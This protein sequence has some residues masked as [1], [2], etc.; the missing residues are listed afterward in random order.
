MY[1][2]ISL[3]S[4][5][6]VYP[7]LAWWTK[8]EEWNSQ[9]DIPLS[10]NNKPKLV[11]QCFPSPVEIYLSSSISPILVCASVVRWILSLSNGRP[12]AS[13]RCTFS[14]WSATAFCA[15]LTCSTNSG[16]SALGHCIATYSK[17]RQWRRLVKISSYSYPLYL[18]GT[19]LLPHNIQWKKATILCV[20]T[21]TSQ[22]DGEP[23]YK[24]QANSKCV[25][26]LSAPEALRK[27]G[28]EDIAIHTMIE[29]KDSW[30]YLDS[31]V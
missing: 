28:I 9:M 22:R 16:C 25:N 8:H 3:R 1:I 10:R 18:A 21:F 29:T 11:A 2:I 30:H 12:S 13:T 15:L 6:N 7:P 4:Q 20:D 14:S 26:Y 19:A 5:P 24:H 23:V 31:L 17:R 27:R